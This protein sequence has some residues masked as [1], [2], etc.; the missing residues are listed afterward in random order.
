MTD[1]IETELVGYRTCSLCEAMCGLEINRRD[2][3]WLI[4]GDRQDPFSKGF[5]CP[6]G[7]TLGAVH[8]DP[9]RL[10]A[11]LIRVGDDPA[12]A[13]WR[14][15]TWDEAF[16]EIDDRFQ[17]VLERH[18]RDALAIYAGNPNVHSHENGLFLPGLIR[19]L[20]S[21]NIFSAS[22]VDQMPKHVS[23]GLLFGDPGAIPV[24][25][26]DR[27]DFLLMLGANPLE[28]N[29][30]LCTAAD[31]PGRL[32]A[33][34]ARG[35]RLVVVDPRRTKTADVGTEH[36]S[37]RPGTDA[38]LLL[39]IAHQLLLGG[40][41]LGSIADVV[42]GVDRLRDVLAP[43]DAESVSAITGID[44]ER[45]RSLAVDLAAA[46]TAAVYARIGSHTTTFGTL[47]SW[48]TDVVNI[49]TGNLDRP[50]GAMFSLPAHGTRG[51]GQGRGF[52]LGRW[53]SR[54]R[55]L[56]EARSE[57]PVA[58]LAEEILTPGA[59][60][61]RALF[62]VA[63]NPALSCPDSER[64]DAA[65]G[66]LEL[67]VSVDPWLNETTRHAHVIL[68]PPGPLARSHYDLAFSGLAVRNNTKWTPALVP[69]EG[70]AEWA[71][72][73][74]LAALVAGAGPAADP[75]L[76]A[77][78]AINDRLE[79]SARTTG[80]S[81]DEMRSA[82]E[83]PGRSPADQLVD[84][85]IR[86]GPYGE[87]FG[88][89]PAGLTL[90][91]VAAE[92]HGIDL[93]PLEPRLPLALKTTDG[94]IDLLPAPLAQDLVRLTD[95]LQEPIDDG[96]VLVGRRHLR[97]NNSWMHNVRVLVKGRPRCTLLVHP[98]DAERLGLDDGKPAQVRSQ[99]GEVQATVEITDRIRPGV[100]SLPH[101][102][103]HDVDGVRLSVAAATDGVNANV[104]TDPG[105]IDPLSGNAQLNAIP[106]E[107]VAV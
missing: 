36:L 94:R 106:V 97:S 21:R 61:I 88:A 74:R 46:P 62:T 37:I 42:D 3:Q 2:G 73:A 66:D 67:L 19:A 4:R 6:K 49:L 85:L 69:A 86:S 16:A 43:F 35:G 59:G 41:D 98:D 89:D 12:T 58:A 101:G 48:A 7:T 84:I 56:A 39:G 25:D 40:V 47:A 17:A 33:L 83:E 79:R 5:V 104:L 91:K 93:G 53:A 99:A 22:T 71:I 26:L 20:G 13:T 24:P 90:D 10:T 8:D 80:R 27:T 92:P 72:L 95:H 60:Q 70:M 77:D 57:L 107:V 52:Q 103:G 82:I 34:V 63:G 45:I 68:P 81:V 28:S 51:E 14:E 15:V 1:T 18:G 105:P 11:P 100:V 96:L 38:H 55:G 75:G 76:L 23:S 65:L 54:V 29:G 30:S 78:A 50:G 102:W 32:E 9:D 64:L 87:G 44:A 31:F